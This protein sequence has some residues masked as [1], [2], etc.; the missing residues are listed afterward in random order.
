MKLVFLPCSGGKTLTDRA[1]H[2]GGEDVSAIQPLSLECCGSWA[3]N[4][5][6]IQ[7]MR[8]VDL[9]IATSI[10]HHILRQLT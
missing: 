1:R 10:N 4:K 5:L 6:L 2:G 8:S 3:S 9:G 7:F